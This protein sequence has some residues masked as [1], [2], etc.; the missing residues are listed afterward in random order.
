MPKKKS[1]SIELSAVS[2][3][4]NQLQ[5]Y[6]DKYNNDDNDID[7][8]NDSLI[9]GSSTIASATSNTSATASTKRKSRAKVEPV[10]RRG[11]PKRKVALN[12]SLAEKSCRTKL[13]RSK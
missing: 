10:K 13:R 5:E 7:Y 4:E 6:L 2:L 9:S 11:R 8:D 3:T 1:M 12:V